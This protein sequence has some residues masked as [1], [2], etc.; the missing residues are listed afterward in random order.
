[1]NKAERICHNQMVTKLQWQ[2]DGVL[3]G[4]QQPNG[5]QIEPFWTSLGHRGHLGR[6]KAGLFFQHFYGR[7]CHYRFVE[8]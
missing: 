8:F 4:L 6:H 1:M 2:A 5:D 3:N 7:K